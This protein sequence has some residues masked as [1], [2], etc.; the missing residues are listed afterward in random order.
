LLPRGAGS[1]LLA[2]ALGQ[3]RRRALHLGRLRPHAQA[4]AQGLRATGAGSGAAG[5]A[6]AGGGGWLLAGGSLGA[7]L[8]A[9]CLLALGVGAGCIALPWGTAHDGRRAG[10]KTPVH[11]ADRAHRASTGAQQALTSATSAQTAVPDQA[12]ASAP[13]GGSSS[14]AARA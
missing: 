10:E 13:A 3:A 7:K 4:G 12:P 6:G 1:E 2:R 5:A 11:S 8:T 14:P 9:A